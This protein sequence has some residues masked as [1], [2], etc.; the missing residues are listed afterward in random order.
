MSMEEKVNELHEMKE[1]ILQM[2]GEKGV[3]KQHARGKLTARE[4]IEKLLDP[5]SFVEIGMFIKHRNTDFGL[6][7]KEL[8]A[9][10]VITGYGTIDGRLV[11]VYA[12]DFTVMGGS[13]GEMHAA[14]IKR[15]MELALEA[16]APII[17]LNDSGGA[18]IQEGVDSLKGYGDI[19]KMNTIMSGIVPQI[20]VIMG[21]CAG[22]AVYSPAIGD[23]IVMVNNPAT[24]MFITGPQVVKAVTGIE[25]SSD[26]LGG[27]MVHA[28]KSGQAHLIANSDEEA[29]ALVRRLVSYLPSNN[30]EKAPK[31]PTSDLPFRKS[32]KLYEIVP[33]DPNKGYD[34]RQV[35]YEIVD[36]D[37]NGNPDFLE[38][39]PY[40]APNAVVGFGRMNGQTV[41]FVANN[42]I[43]LAGVLDI[44]SSDKIARFVRTC[45]AYN[46]PIVTLVDVPGYLPG[47]QQEYGGIIRHGAKVLYAYA[48][49]TV[50]LVTIILRKA[51]GGAYL[52]MGSKHLGADFVYAWPTAEIAVMGPEGAANI[53]FR[54]EIAKAENPEEF[55]QQK[56]KEYRDKFANPYVAAGR[57]YIDDVID[58]AE[59]RG[60]IIMALEALSSKRVKLPPKKHGNIPL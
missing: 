13:L 55:R 3:E 4:R 33:D 59:T 8:P 17:G 12:Q 14:K 41:G 2:G 60:R 20:T 22:G 21:P 5:G 31:L 37:A 43:H 19:F 44:D 29:L 16:G 25:V 36:R 47:V 24:F 9:D 54:K 49:A 23:F 46:I 42:P 32:E 57:G 10:G 30:M 39:L 45:D 26:Q 6:G 52:A 27:G 1:R 15:V 28:Q 58:P 35:I 51:Y 18:R 50:P 38:I 56:I 53:I 48:E 11:F 34:V 7:E 40:Y